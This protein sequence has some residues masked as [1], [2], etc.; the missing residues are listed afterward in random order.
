MYTFSA[1]FTGYDR[2]MLCLKV[3]RKACY[4]LEV[5]GE[6]R[7]LNI[8]EYRYP[9]N[10][11]SA[12]IQ[13]FHR[14]YILKFN[15]FSGEI[16]LW[17]VSEKRFCYEESVF[18]TFHQASDQ[19]HM[20]LPEVLELPVCRKNLINLPAKERKIAER[21]ISENTEVS[22]LLFSWMFD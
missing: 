14:S 17:D 16:G 8:S 15:C 19:Y 6:L 12:E 5:P 18:R 11:I 22:D 2:E 10:Y 20:L 13:G 7:V 3:F 21:W 9:D 1:G 4:S